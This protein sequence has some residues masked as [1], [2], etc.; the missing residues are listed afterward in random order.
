MYELF[1]SK[2]AKKQ[3]MKL[4]KKNQEH[5][6]AVLERARIRPHAFFTRI[7]GGKFF[8]LKAGKYRVIAD[9]KQN[10]LIILVLKVAHRKKI[11]K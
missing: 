9:I 1:Y 6:L 11:Y 3:I 7:V 5:I 10:K 4:E 2:K 8:R